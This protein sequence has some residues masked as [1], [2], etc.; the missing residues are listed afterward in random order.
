[1]GQWFTGLADACRET[2]YPVTEVPGWK[3][4]GHGPMANHVYG[5]L[6]HHTAGPEP[7]RTKSNMPSLNVLINGYSGL[8]GPLSQIGLGFDGRIYVIA[9]GLC[10]HGG[11]GS[12]RGVSGNGYFLGIEA[13]DG[14]DGDWTPAQ[15]DCYPRLNAVL[16]QF[17]DVGPGWVAGHKE[18]AP[19]RKIDPAG[20]NMDQ[21]R[22]KVAWYL[23]HPNQIRKQDDD[24]PLTDADKKWIQ[25]AIAIGAKQ[26][27]GEVM[28]RD[29]IP[30]PWEVEEGGNKNWKLK[31]ADAHSWAW[32]RR[33]GIAAEANQKAL[34]KIG[35]AIEA[36]ADEIPEASAAAVRE[37]L[38]DLEVT[39]SYSLPADDENTE[40][41]S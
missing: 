7:E 20:I 33:S 31:Y 34:V 9:A 35:K 14:G 4:R 36:L 11:A 21:M 38:A 18:Y 16:C 13:E 28:N 25:D 29:A 12:W 37:Q 5:I 32:A 2:G 26:A 30:V 23:N 27:A 3:T 19:T 39:L 17:L 15:L 24:M 8:P 10:Y 41:P 22:Q 40:Q 6:D 1:M